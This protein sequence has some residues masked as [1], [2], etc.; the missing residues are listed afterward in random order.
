MKVNI[1]TNESVKMSDKVRTY[2][3]E[4]V[5]SLEKLFNTS[6]HVV[7]NVLCKGYEKYSVVEITIPL[8]HIVLRAESK[9]D[10][11]YGAVD[12]ATDKV[13]RQLLRHKQK[14]NSMIKKRDG[15]S[16]YFSQKSLSEEK[17]EPLVVAKTKVIEK[18]VMSVDE[19][20]T[21]MELSD[22][23]FFAFVNEANYRH[24]VVYIRKDGSYGLLEIKE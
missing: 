15:I 21:Q 9:A 4:H 7:A 23:D 3:E 14:V 12:L 17:S 10:T 8:K 5:L 2:I 6:E 11:L 22:H 13:E 1:R 16:D 19:A 18:D 24:T 20:I